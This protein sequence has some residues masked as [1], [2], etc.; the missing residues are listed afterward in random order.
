MAKPELQVVVSE[1]L[2]ASFRKE[3][4]SYI[5]LTLIQDFDVQ[6]VE[7][8]TK[9]GLYYAPE[10]DVFV[11]LFKDFKCPGVLSIK[12]EKASNLVMVES[13]ICDE[14][15]LANPK[16]IVDIYNSS[17]NLRDDSKSYIGIGEMLRNA[18]SYL[19]EVLFRIRSSRDHFV[20]AIKRLSSSLNEEEK[21]LIGLYAIFKDLNQSELAALKENIAKMKPV[22]KQ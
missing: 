15:H 9:P 20:S 21:A 18:D 11:G 6:I 3:I 2:P 1:Y 7:K 16:Q 13:S 17:A 14:F 22:E 5:S 8:L 12:C 10:N 19:R 4:I